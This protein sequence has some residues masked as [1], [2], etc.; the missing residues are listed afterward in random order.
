MD[1]HIGNID[2]LVKIL[3]YVLVYS[4]N[5]YIVRHAIILS[6]ANDLLIGNNHWLQRRKNIRDE[7]E[8]RDLREFAEIS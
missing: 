1:T 8:I 6:A 5:T 4:R 3:T 7:R 2:L